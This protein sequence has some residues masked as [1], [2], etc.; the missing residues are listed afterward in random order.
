MLKTGSIILSIWSGLNLFLAFLILILI[1]FL[2]TDA[3][4][5]VMV[6]EESESAG[7]DAR[8]ISAVNCLAILYNSCAAALSVL[9]LYVT[10]S[11]LIN[12]QRK[13]FWLLLVTIGFVQILAF[14]AWAA[15]GNARWQVNAVLSALYIVGI[16]LAGF[17]IF[18]R[19]AHT[20]KLRG[21]LK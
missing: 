9:A 15:V 3:P 1:I 8:A 12:G 4:I 16:G 21:T 7:L 5:L 19:Q 20:I 11:S 18:K 2:D 10:W 13:A 17:A 14:V 6:F